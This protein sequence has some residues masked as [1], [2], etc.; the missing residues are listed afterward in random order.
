MPALLV[1]LGATPF[2]PLIL[3][4]RA[5]YPA[6]PSLSAIAAA[7]GLT[8][9]I[10]LVFGTYPRCARR[11]SIPLQHC[12]ASSPATAG[13]STPTLHGALAEVLGRPIVTIGAPAEPR[14]V[15]GRS[16]Q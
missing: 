8:V 6:P 4:G 2:V 12:G 1:G 9:A 3:G 10:R 15:S 14:R 16:T 5:S 13:P 11:V 7:L